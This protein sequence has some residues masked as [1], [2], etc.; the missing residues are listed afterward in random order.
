MNERIR[1]IAKQAGLVYVLQP[2]NPRIEEDFQ[3][4]AELIVK[5]YTE[6]MVQANMQN[7]EYARAMDAYYEQKWAHRFD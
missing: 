7:P 5:D 4:F 1:E 6:K 2:C 3:K